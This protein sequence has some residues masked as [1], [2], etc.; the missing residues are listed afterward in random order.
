[1]VKADS[2]IPLVAPAQAER[3]ARRRNA[4]ERALWDVLDGVYDP[5][6]PVL[7]LW[8]LGVLRDV[9]RDGE[10]V[11]VELT[12]T[13]SGCPAFE[14]MADAVRAAL[15]SA[16]HRDV[17]IVTRLAPAWTTDWLD[18]AAR[19]RLRQHGIAPP[20]RGVRCPQCGATDTRLASEFAATACL[21]L[22]RCNECAEPFHLFKAI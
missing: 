12:P 11:T 5:E 10:Y 16:G 19:E 6:I 13:Y 15:A 17:R 4:T 1:V 14:A 9:R 21:A 7:S 3:L 22:Y 18:A 20:E 2:V 8:D